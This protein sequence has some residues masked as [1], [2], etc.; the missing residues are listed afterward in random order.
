MKN[1]SFSFFTNYPFLI[2]VN[3]ID[4]K[5]AVRTTFPNNLLQLVIE[6]YKLR[7]N[8]SISPQ[9]YMPAFASPFLSLSRSRSNDVF[10][11][12]GEVPFCVH[13]NTIVIIYFVG[14]FFQL[15]LCLPK[16]TIC[17]SHPLPT[18]HFRQM[19]RL[20]SCRPFGEF[21]VY[22]RPIDKNRFS[23]NYFSIVI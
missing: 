9:T 4:R 19:F 18:I 22:A 14:W 3:K 2:L 17:L 7:C 12:V 16:N 5:Q 6:Y 1:K 15:C 23:M 13:S 8:Y 11:I 20:S 21:D 10:N